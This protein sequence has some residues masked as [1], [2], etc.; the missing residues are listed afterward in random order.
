MVFGSRSY[1][2]M[3][4]DM[5]TAIT[6]PSSPIAPADQPMKIAVPKARRSVSG[7]LMLENHVRYYVSAVQDTLRK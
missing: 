4:H 7:E 5:Q 6:L 3:E 1:S 2:D